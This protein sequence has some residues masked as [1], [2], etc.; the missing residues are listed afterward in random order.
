MKKLL[1][2]VVL[3]GAASAAVLGSGAGA[4][5]PWETFGSASGSGRG[6]YLTPEGQQPGF[7]HLEITSTTKARPAKVRAALTDGNYT[8][9]TTV[10]VSLY[11]F[12]GERV[13]NN[14]NS[15]YSDYSLPKTL[16]FD[17]PSWVSFCQ[18]RAEAVYGKNGPLAMTLQAQY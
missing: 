1:A 5:T 7:A 9:K 4:A 10:S 11:C 13:W 18:V 12:N 17:P 6:H 3:V 16:T 8:G 15:E 2:A 14:P